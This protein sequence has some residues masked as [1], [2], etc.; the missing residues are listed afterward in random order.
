M[1]KVK[2]IESFSEL[3]KFAQD[4]NKLLNFNKFYLFY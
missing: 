1:Q 2:S 4:N 3:L